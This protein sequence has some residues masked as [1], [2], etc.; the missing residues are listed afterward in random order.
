MRSHAPLRIIIAL[1]M[2]LT[3][4]PPAFGSFSST[5]TKDLQAAGGNAVSE[6]DS[7][8][9]SQLDT[10][11]DGLSF[12][13]QTDDYSL[14]AAGVFTA[15]GL[16]S[17]VGIPGEPALPYY[18]T[19]I[20]LPPEATAQVSIDVSG[21]QTDPLSTA[22]RPAPRPDTSSAG[23]ADMF[24]IAEQV[25]ELVAYEPDPAIYNTDSTYPAA[26][27]QVSAPMYAR[28][29]RLVELKLFPFRY[30]PVQQSVEIAGSMQVSIQFE[31][32]EFANMRPA[33][34]HNDAI[35]R[36]MAGSILNLEQ[37]G[38]WRSLPAGGGPGHSVLPEGTDAYRIEVNEDGLYEVD[39]AQLAVAGMSVN[40]VNPN[41]FQMV[42]RGQ[43][44]AYEFVGD[45]DNSFEPGEAVR[46]YG[47]RFDGSR[48]ER[49]FI[50]EYRN[51][52][53]LWAGGTATHIGDT[54]NPPGNPPADTFPESITHE[55]D[56]RFQVTETNNWPNY[57]NEP[58]SWYWT[59]KSKAAGSGDETRNFDIE[60]VDPASS[61]G[62]AQITVEILNREADL[63]THIVDTYANG[64][65]AYAG[66]TTWLG[67]RNVNITTTQPVTTMVNGTNQVQVVFKTT[68]NNTSAI[69]YLNRITIDYPRQFIARN[70]QLQFQTETGPHTFTISDFTENNPANAL[71][72]DISDR[73]QPQRIPM[74]A[75]NI[76]GTGPYN[77]TFGSNNNDGQYLATTPNNTLIP[78]DITQYVVP[79]I[80]PAGNN[81][82]WLA[83][84]AADF[85]VEANNLAAHR[86]NSIYGGLD[87]HV[88]DI[89][90]VINQYGYGFPIPGAIKDYLAYAVNDWSTS[91]T[92]V[93]LVGDATLNPRQLPCLETN[94]GSTCDLWGTD[95][96]P[97]YVLT[98]FTF[99][100]RYSGFMTSDFPFTLLDGDDL[101]DLTI[102]RLAVNTPTQAQNIIDKIIDYEQQHLAPAD[103]QLNVLF[104]ADDADEA[105]NFCQENQ[106]IDAHIPDPFLETQVCLPDN[107]TQQ[108][109]DAMR[110]EMRMLAVTPPNG[111]TFMNYRGHG[112]IEYWGE[113]EEDQ[114]IMNNTDTGWWYPTV[115]DPHPLILLSMDCLDANFAWP[116]IDGLG[117][118]FHRL[119]HAGSVAHW[120]STGL[121]LTSEHTVLQKGF[122]D[123]LFE[124]GLLHIGEAINHAK[125]VYYQGGNDISEMYGFTLH[126][127]P[128]MLLMRPEMEIDKIANVGSV[129]PG[130]Q[131][132]F[133]LKVTNNGLYTA[134][135]TVVDQLP[136]GLSYVSASANVPITVDVN[137]NT[138]TISF[139]NGLAYGDTGTI[140]LTTLLDAGYQGNSITNSATVSENTGFDAVPG[141]NTDS[142]TVITG[143][144]I[145][146]Y[147]PVV[148]RQG[149]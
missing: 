27:Y 123:G 42:Y 63:W 22:I 48:A 44:V 61:S 135:P 1:A 11:E 90:D 129:E 101:A 121:G 5:P 114:Q 80:D 54:N 64:E 118:T 136:A 116:G 32:A 84:S 133:T 87:T 47:W 33:P 119:D 38:E 79:N 141:N 143:E 127:D 72:W 68:N 30:N 125:T 49:Q 66:N 124:E 139:L 94:H 21:V 95:V 36:A 67:R 103:W 9:I 51:Y 13:F 45:G 91:P 76:G 40:L 122:Y 55:E 144:T 70:N 126:G 65:A 20:A 142:A 2:I 117:E 69:Y 74:T 99:L 83:I 29:L 4:L 148:L 16:T 18:A 17:R 97:N 115:G 111:V 100:D 145:D 81:A 98:D 130:E 112:S 85:M 120:S 62:D 35:V 78:L 71:V 12:R 53:W 137:G 132:N 57:P 147:L 102:G 8:L 46:F 96:V 37:A 3:I 106:S 50:P 34:S 56:R 104:G 6:L 15:E 109:I 28:D 107:P 24:R 93:T 75:G 41:T 39:Y 43:P 131:L 7:P 89:E 88:V 140:T 26:Y 59:S 128:A 77:W 110:A 23:E 60:L 146:I 25:D 113:S 10:G 105:G 86:R 31:G 108:D 149:N 58:D 14:D 52:Y 92:Y 82:E 138:I 19:Y 73:L 134:K